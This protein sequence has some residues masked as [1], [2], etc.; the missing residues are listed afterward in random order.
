MMMNTLLQLVT[1]YSVASMVS[2][3]YRPLTC[4]PVRT[5]MCSKLGADGYAMTSFPNF[6]NHTSQDQSISEL[7]TYSQLL[8]SRQAPL[9]TLFICSVFIPLCTP[10]LGV[11]PPCRSLCTKAKE[12]VSDAF[13][14][15]GVK[16]PFDCGRYPVEAEGTLCI[17]H[18]PASPNE[19][20]TVLQSAIKTKR[21]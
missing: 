21:K 5:P 10:G 4:E 14:A 3:R 6:V 11:V 2:G 7:D 17:T 18:G 13:R 1:I 9:L 15:G 8:Q 19:I 16:W 20:P 12:T